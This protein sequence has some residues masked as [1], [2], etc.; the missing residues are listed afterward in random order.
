MVILDTNIIIELYKGNI[1][2]RAICEEL[3]E[4]NL[5]VSSIVV[6]EFYSGV[7]DKK[8]LLLIQKHIRKFPIVHINETIS[9][10][11]VG[12]MERYCLSHHPYIGDML[13]AAT[14]L[15]YNSPLYT[16]NKKDFRHIAK[17][18]LI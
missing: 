4:E 14:A 12:L 7:R 10:I 8:E 18:G 5:F 16:L 1:Q 6:S 11:A 13:I 17:L 2:V 9:E 15:H 3:E